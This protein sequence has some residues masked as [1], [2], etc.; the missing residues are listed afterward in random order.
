MQ[1]KKRA[2]SKK[3]LLKSNKSDLKNVRRKRKI[4]TLKE[5]FTVRKLLMWLLILIVAVSLILG[6][7]K[8]LKKDSTIQT[9]ETET[10]IGLEAKNTLALHSLLTSS[11]LNS[12]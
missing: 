2:K 12:K 4:K 3:V 5:K 9:E 10:V 6:T 7:V 11:F 1:S 8:I